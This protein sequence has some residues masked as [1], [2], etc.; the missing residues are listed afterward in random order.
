ML[1]RVSSV[2]SDASDCIARAHALAPLI[3]ANAAR[4]EQERE[5]VP[6]VL[7]ALHEARLFRMLLPR[8]CGG[9]EADP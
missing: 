4:I 2:E 3:A 9:W 6:E 5:I 1:E 8:S 7:T